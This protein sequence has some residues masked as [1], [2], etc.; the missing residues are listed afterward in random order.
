MKLNFIKRF[1]FSLI[2]LFALFFVIMFGVKSNPLA[3]HYE[4][5]GYDFVT[6]LKYYLFD[7]PTK[8]ITDVVDTFANYESTTRELELMQEYI[9]QMAIL[10]ELYKEVHEENEELKKLLEMKTTSSE[11]DFHVGNVIARDIDGW[12]SY[13]TI[14]LGSDDGISENQAVITSQGLIGKVYMVSNTS[15]IVKLITSEDGLNKAALK[16]MQEDVVEAILE[17]YDAEEKMLMLRV[18]DNNTDIKIGS[19]VTT[20][21]LSGVYPNGILVGTVERVDSVNNILGKIVYVKPAANFKNINKVAVIDRLTE[22]VL[23]DE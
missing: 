16:I 8:K 10:N 19:S 9:N 6:S 3:N 11:F 4:V 12:N 5:V 17:Y 13:I 20:S 14:D 22:E 23:T 15:S 2:V 18:L 21:A 7:K 1:L